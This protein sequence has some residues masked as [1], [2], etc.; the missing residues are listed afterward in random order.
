MI[1]SEFEGMQI[2]M[3][4]FGTMRLPVVDPKEPAGI[5]EEKTEE[6]IDYALSHGIKYFDTAYFYH[7]EQSERVVGRILKKYPREN[8]YL[9]TKFPG[10]QIAKRFYPAETFE[11]QL[12]KCGVEFFDFYL[13]HNVYEK[14]LKNYTDPRWKIIDYLVEEKKR[15]RV[16]YL[17]F[18]THGNVEMIEKFCDDYA[19]VFDFCQIQ[20]NYLDWTLQN[21]KAKY[22]LLTQRKIPIWV[23]E[24]IRGGRLAC[25]DGTTEAR[26]KKLRPNESVASW[27]MRWL[28][29][30][31]NVKV[32]LSGMTYLE[33]IKDNLK[34]FKERKTLTEKEIGLLYEI[35]AEM[36]NSISCTACGYCCN[37]CPME[38]DIPGLLRLYR[39]F[40]MEA[41]L[42]LGMRMDLVPENKRPSA[43]IG[44]G[45]CGDT[46]PQKIDVT[47]HMKEF[48]AV[49]QQAP[50]W[51]QICLDRERAA[52]RC[53]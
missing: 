30:L 39:D 8:Y 25:M 17:G 29:G 27:A 6:L 7:G 31:P 47:K 52:A 34:S 53:D 10:Y 38:L 14:S 3:L 45:R 48:A 40:K 12:R 26:M 41:S 13:L 46:C 50:N 11:K 35:A 9:A 22:E 4:G 18:S 19:G 20:L 33:D 49:W 23:M 32:V 2:P 1:C 42:P 21:A 28:Q 16:R 44:C 24:P 5:D 51:T 43:C 36:N 37:V 15:G